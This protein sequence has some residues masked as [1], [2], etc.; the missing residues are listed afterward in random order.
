[1]NRILKI[2]VSV[3][4]FSITAFLAQESLAAGFSQ[5]NNITVQRITGNLTLFCSGFQPGG[6]QI[7]YVR[8]DADLWTPGPTDYFVGPAADAD[9][10][11]LNATHADGSQKSKSSKYDGQ[12]GQSQSQ[13]NLGIWTVTQKPLLQEGANQIH[14]SLAKGSQAVTEG[15]F[16]AT[17]TRTQAAIC[18]NGSQNAFGNDCDFPQRA[19][20]QYFEQYHYC[21]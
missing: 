13:F 18:P 20:D 1:M 15:D 5:G 4:A 21:Q 16:T 7:K 10:V 2:A 12:K 19:C 14:F 9:Q 11:T 3:L 8:C 17:V 6:P